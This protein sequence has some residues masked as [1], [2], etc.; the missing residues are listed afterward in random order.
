[1]LSSEKEIKLEYIWVLR[2]RMTDY[3]VMDSRILFP[4]RAAKSIV[5]KTLL[6]SSACNVTTGL[7]FNSIIL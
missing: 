6:H 5:A 1:L 2:L 3:V 4:L 7:G